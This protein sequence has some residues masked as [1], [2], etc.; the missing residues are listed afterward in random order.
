MDARFRP[1]CG[2][3]GVGSVRYGRSRGFDLEMKAG[4]RP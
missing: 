2:T 3:D 4:F 1:Q